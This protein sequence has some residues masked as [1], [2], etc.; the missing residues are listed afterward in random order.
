MNQ[1]TLLPSPNRK[2]L[3]T[4]LLILGLKNEKSQA[5]LLTAE[6]I[7]KSSFLKNNSNKSLIAQNLEC[8]DVTFKWVQIGHGHAMNKE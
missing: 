5:S 4:T 6:A 2:I 8:V 7:H 3:H 1:K